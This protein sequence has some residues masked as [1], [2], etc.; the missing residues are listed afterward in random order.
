MSTFPNIL[1]TANVTTIIEN[2]DPA[3]CKNNRPISLLSN[4]RKVFEKLNHARLSAFL[5]ANNVLYEKQFGFRNQYSI[6][7]A[8]IEI[9]EKIKQGRDSGKFACGVFLDFENVFDT[10]N[11]NILLKKLS[12]MEYVISQTNGSGHS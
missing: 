6:D 2:D 9:S 5:S 8:L 12:T 10:V 1:K 3:L 4:I 11:H 7:H